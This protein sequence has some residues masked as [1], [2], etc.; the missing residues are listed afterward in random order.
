MPKQSKKPRAENRRGI[1]DGST[2]VPMGVKIPAR[3]KAQIDD[4]LA[5]IKKT[6]PCYNRSDL[7][8][9]MLE[10]RYQPAH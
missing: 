10:Q 1:A 4:E 8:R 5:F 6:D 7:M 2:L 3:L 9:D